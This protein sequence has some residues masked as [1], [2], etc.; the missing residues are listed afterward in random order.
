M[1]DT[2]GDRMKRYENVNRA[3]LPPRTYT[4][5]RVDGR[6]FHTLL[7]KAERPFDMGVVNL[8]DR[9]ALALC[10]DMSGVVFAYTQSDE[11]SVLMTD[12]DT[13]DRQPWFGGVVQKIASVSASIATASFN[14][15]WQRSKSPQVPMFD[16]RVWSIPEQCEV[17]NYFLWRQRDAIRNSIQM[18]A[19]SE[20]AHG[21]LQGLDTNQLQEKLWQERGIN[22]NDLDIGLKRGR[23]IVR[24]SEVCGEW[25]ISP[26]PHFQATPEHWLAM[27]IPALAPISPP[28][29]QIGRG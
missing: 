20:F 9:V 14:Y 6:A 22:W 21:D 28:G 17:A 2:L 26:A 4:L 10:Q 25:K 11:V 1:S 7:K 18:L 27:V 29:R 15:G 12:F 8:M 5:V 3:V 16:G 19:Q 13:H 24:D 23:V